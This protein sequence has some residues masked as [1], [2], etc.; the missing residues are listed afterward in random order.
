MPDQA[1]MKPSVFLALR[2]LTLARIWRSLQMISFVSSV[3]EIGSPIVNSGTFARSSWSRVA[4]SASV[5]ELGQATRS[6][7]L[8]DLE[9]ETHWLVN[10]WHRRQARLL[11]EVECSV[12]HGRRWRAG[13]ISGGFCSPK[14]S[15][16][17]AIARCRRRSVRRAMDPAP[18]S[19]GWPVAD[20]AAPVA[21]LE[22]KSCGRPAATLPRPGRRGQNLSSQ[23]SFCEW[24][25]AKLTRS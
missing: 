18:A 24:C 13:N 25:T 15:R 20:S 4:V 1:S 2:W 12:S 8:I 21:V 19:A 16:S 11:A 17:C 6:R 7:I 5:I 3:L 14:A 9:V 23:F 10:Y 22:R